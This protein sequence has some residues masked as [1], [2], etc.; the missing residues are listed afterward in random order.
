M[1]VPEHLVLRPTDESIQIGGDPALALRILGARIFGRVA[2][3][4]RTHVEPAYKPVHWILGDG[5][6][7]GS[8]VDDLD[9]LAELG[10]RWLESAGVKPSDVLVGMVAPGP[11]LAYWE[12]VLGARRAGLSALHLDGIPAAEDVERLRP[13]VLA[14]ASADLLELFEEAAVG[15]P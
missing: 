10:R 6:P 3:V 15:E 1:A 11:S 9:R 12:L 13:S 7:I 14:G 8:S 5:V 4:S 2:H